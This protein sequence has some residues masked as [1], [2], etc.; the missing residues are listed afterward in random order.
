MYPTL[1]LASYVPI[2]DSNGEASGRVSIDPQI[3]VP[4][5][6][7]SNSLIAVDSVQIIGCNFAV[8]H[9]KARVQAQNG[10]LDTQLLGQSQATWHDWTAPQ[11][12]SDLML[13]PVSLP[14]AARLKADYVHA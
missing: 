5:S 11:M 14:P 1:F 4:F 3:E 13:S 7:G 2:V 6:T 8:N 10:S 12:S 9:S